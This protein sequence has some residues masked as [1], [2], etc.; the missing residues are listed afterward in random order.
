MRIKLAV[1]MI[2]VL[3]DLNIVSLRSRS[4][5]S[6]TG[7]GLNRSLVLGRCPGSLRGTDGGL[8][9]KSGP[10]RLYGLKRDNPSLPLSLD[11]RFF[12]NYNK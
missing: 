5:Y 4:P 11:N 9:K 7:P 2:Q 8:R 12:T 1:K 6:K 3:R 10:R